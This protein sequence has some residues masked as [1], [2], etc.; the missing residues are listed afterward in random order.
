MC[1]RIAASAGPLLCSSAV[2]END[3]LKGHKGRAR[4]RLQQWGVRVW[5]DVIATNR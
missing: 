4:E 1:R 2:T 5:S 3:A